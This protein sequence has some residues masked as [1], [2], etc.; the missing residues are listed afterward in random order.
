MSHQ[1]RLEGNFRRIGLLSS[2]TPLNDCPYDAVLTQWNSGTTSAN[3]IT[4]YCSGTAN[5]HNM[6]IEGRTPKISSRLATP[7]NPPYVT[8]PSV[9]SPTVP[10]YAI[11]AISV[12]KVSFAGE[13]YKG[14]VLNEYIVHEAAYMQAQTEKVGNRNNVCGRNAHAVR[15]C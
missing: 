2:S 11:T 1:R 10:V 8:S 5:K 9:H 14:R 12:V 4:N 15:K 3:M 13:R 6:G 7:F